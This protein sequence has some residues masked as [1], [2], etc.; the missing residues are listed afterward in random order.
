MLA[1]LS[2]YAVLLDASTG[3]ETA[4][5]DYGG[6]SLV[7]VDTAGSGVALLLT[8]GGDASLILLDNSLAPLAQADA[9]A[10][11]SLCATRTA[12]YLTA[13]SLVQCL[14][15]NGALQWEKTLDAPPLAILDASQPLVFTGTE[16]SVLTQ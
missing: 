5:Y 13:G 15:Y 2:D 7:D 8:G 16:V 1:V 6:A 10:A 11:E 3:A 14:D 4:R 9:G 12:L